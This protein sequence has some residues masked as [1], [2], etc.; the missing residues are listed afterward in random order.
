[1]QLMCFLSRNGMHRAFRYDLEKRKSWMGPPKAEI[2]ITQI[3][4]H[5]DYENSSLMFS[6]SQKTMLIPPSKFDANGTIKLSCKYFRFGW[7]PS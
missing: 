3:V 6:G 5:A 4:D 2:L 1:M 7:P